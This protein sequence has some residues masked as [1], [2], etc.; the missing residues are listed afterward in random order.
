M[1]QMFPMNWLL[2]YITFIIIFLLYLIKIY[3]SFI[4]KIPNNY[5]MKMFKYKINWKW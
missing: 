3:F 4:Q 1:P 2:I 5:K